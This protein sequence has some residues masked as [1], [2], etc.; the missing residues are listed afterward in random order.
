MVI[1]FI[2]A[3]VIKTVIIPHFGGPSEMDVDAEFDRLVLV[4]F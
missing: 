3:V 4:P 1:A 2:N